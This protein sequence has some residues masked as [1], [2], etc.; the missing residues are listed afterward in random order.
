MTDIPWN[1][2]HRVNLRAIDRHHQ[3]LDNSFDDL[4]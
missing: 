1:E 3:Q 4:H 2:N